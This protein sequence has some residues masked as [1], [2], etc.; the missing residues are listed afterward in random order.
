M[1]NA[2]HVVGLAAVF[3]VVA[4][5]VPP[6]VDADT[7]ELLSG[8]DGVGNPLPGCGQDGLVTFTSPSVSTSTPAIA[9]VGWPSNPCDM[10]PDCNVV[11]TT[12]SQCVTTTNAY[13]SSATFVATFELPPGFSAPRLILDL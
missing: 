10:L 11:G 4:A 1:R 2:I 13:D 9:G 12:I 7:I 8:S 6:P 5:L 3:P